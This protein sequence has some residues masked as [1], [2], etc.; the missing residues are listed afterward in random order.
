MKGVMLTRSGNRTP[1]W[2]FYRSIGVNVDAALSNAGLPIDA[3]MHPDS[4]ISYH[5]VLAA[6]DLLHRR[7]P[8]Q[9]K[10][11]HI[12]SSR[13]LYGVSNKALRFVRSK[14]GLYGKLRAF[15][16]CAATAGNMCRVHFEDTGDAMRL[17]ATDRTPIPRSEE[18]QLFSDWAKVFPIINAARLHL[19]DEWR[20]R[21]IGFRARRQCCDEAMDYFSSTDMRFGQTSVWVE[22]PFDLLAQEVWAAPRGGAGAARSGS[23]AD[24]DGFDVPD[25]NSVADVLRHMFPAYLSSGGASLNEMAEV[26]G[27]SRRTLQRRLL[28]ENATFSGLLNEVRLRYASELLADRHIKIID[29]AVAT[30]FEHPTHFTRAFR[31]QTGLS[32]RAYRRSLDTKQVQKAPAA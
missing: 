32:P 9:D 14:V 24:F 10:G 18:G 7:E 1:I 13:Q 22:F 16:E 2:D 23:A 19:G 25:F 4:L 31:R 3:E 5:R 26:L 29:I 6:S 17:Y 8:I 21:Q 27:L 20:P 12:Y 11:W 28:H 30:G 15:A